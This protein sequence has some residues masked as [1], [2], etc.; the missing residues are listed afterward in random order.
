[1]VNV[2]HRRG[3]TPV[4]GTLSS[5]S[6]SHVPLSLTQFFSR[7]HP[8]AE[9]PSTQDLQP[10]GGPSPRTD[11]G[12]MKAQPPAIGQDKVKS[13]AAP[14]VPS[15]M[16]VSLGPYPR[17]CLFLASSSF[18]PP[19]P[20]LTPPPPFPQEAPPLQSPARNATHGSGSH[21]R[22]LRTDRGT[23]VIFRISK[24]RESSSTQS[25]GV[26]QPQRPSLTAP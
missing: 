24:G 25:P 4:P 2:G 6:C 10:P 21:L 17:S 14:R 11:S 7:S 19:F 3:S 26:E 8:G 5:V 9:S 15:E 20:H 12:G 22:S 18:F 16:T 23:R 13:H 1:M